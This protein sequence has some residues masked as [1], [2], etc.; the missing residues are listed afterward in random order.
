MATQARILIVDDEQT[1]REL[2]YE[3]LSRDGY[4]C[5][6]ASDAKMA[7]AKLEQRTFDLAISDIRMP[8]GNGIA[9]L[10]EMRAKYPDT[11][12]IMATAVAELEPAI[13]S[14]KM[15]AQDYLLK[16]FNLSELSLSVK[17]AL[18]VRR[19]ERENRDYHLH[20]EEKVKEQTQ[21]IQ[22]LFLG[23][24][25]ALAEALEAKDEYTRGHSQRVTEL[26][27]GVAQRLGLADEE[28][29]KVVL[30]AELHDIGK[31]G[32][33]DEVL[34]KP[35]PLTKEEYEHVLS[36]VVIG[37]KILRPI[38]REES[39]LAM[40]K[41]HHEH[42]DGSGYPDRL[43]G[44]EIP[45]GARILAVVDAYDA[46]TSSRPYRQALP[47]QEAKRLLLDANGTQFYPQAVE[48]L[49]AIL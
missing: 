38:L 47:P 46:M 8:G 26:S 32:V 9:L 19:L 18:N 16:P 15:G 3:S 33:R 40:V 44:E 30:A 24:I 10:Q 45:F 21:T 13:E 23:G 22:E 49:L 4:E 29:N 34:K 39:T 14:L 25:R 5:H 35:G 31:I 37:E 6:T 17:N 2:L 36:H 28:L 48:A 12:V 7:L 1:M 20:L 43:R 27:Q 41:H 11:A 42:W